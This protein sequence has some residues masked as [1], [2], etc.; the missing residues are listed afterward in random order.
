VSAVKHFHPYLYGRHFTV[1]TDHAALCW[2]LSFRHPEGQIARWLQRL[3]EY[4]FKVEH[5]A[6]LSH[7]NADALSRRPCLQQSCRH[8]DRLDTQER[9]QAETTTGVL[10]PTKDSSEPTTLYVALTSLQTI[11]PEMELENRPWSHAELHTAQMQDNE[12]QP[13]MEWLEKSDTKPPW[14]VVAP[15]SA[16]TKNY[17]AQ[18][19][20]LCLKD[21]VLYRLWETPQGDQVIWQIVLPKPLRPSV[22]HQLHNTPTA[23]HLAVA[24]TLN[25]VRERFYWVG[26][27]QDVQDW[28]QSCDLCASR[29]GPSRRPRAPMS[30]YNVGA[31]ME[32][33]A[34]DVLRPLP[35]SN[36][37]NKY[38][39]IVADYFTKWPEA[40]PLPN[41]EATTVAEVLVNEFVCRFGVPLEIHSDQLL[42]TSDLKHNCKVSVQGSK[43]K[44]DSQHNSDSEECP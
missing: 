11:A 17:W 14:D 40:Y 27:H 10:D 2:L 25:R 7:R 34:L 38:L 32:R 33:L 31:P 13:V 23:G 9:S 35:V 41:Q 43:A 15:C 29:K 20:S 1:R 42:V 19:D 3:Q 22:L 37:G 18:W 5:R 12:I 16:I 21:G 36:A 6:G 28:C 39:L 24:K 8:C 26:C 44:E 30:Q 4:D